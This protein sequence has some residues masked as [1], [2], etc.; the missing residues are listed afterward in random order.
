MFLFYVSV[1][2]VRA[3]AAVPAALTAAAVL[4]TVLALGGQRNA[5]AFPAYSKK[6]KKPCSFCHV[7]AA[8]GGKRNAAG[9]YYKTHKLS[10]VGFKPAGAPAKP[11]PAAK[12]PAKKG[13]APPASKK[14]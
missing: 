1:Q 5:E 9:I 3:A 12:P 6:E 8:G 2:K 10:L 13:G 14:G 11:A 7:N 4:C